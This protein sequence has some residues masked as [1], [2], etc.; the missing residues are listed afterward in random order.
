MRIQSLILITFTLLLTGCNSNQDASKAEL[1]PVPVL[2]VTPTV[3]DVPVYIESIGTLHPSI[4]MEIRPQVNGTLRKV[5][6][7]EGEWVQKGTPLFKIDPKPYLNKVQETEAQLAMDRA[8]QESAQKKLERFKSLAEKDLIPQIEWDEIETQVARSQ[9]AVEADEARLNS[10]KLDL[11]HCTLFSPLEGRIGKLDAHPGQLVTSGQSTP[12]VTLSKMDPLLVEFTITEKE[13]LKLPQN[14][15]EVEIQSLSSDAV[16]AKGV[17][18]FLDNH[19]DQKSGLLLVR[20]KVDN[21]N[22]ALRPG[23]SVRVRLVVETASNVKLIP[24]KAV[25]Y[26]PQGP[27]VYIVESDQSVGM[28]PVQLGDAQANDVIVLE[29]IESIDRVITD[30]HLRLYP[31]LKVEVSQ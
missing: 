9:A 28:R 31:G 20:G 2:A 23:Q 29:G 12:L 17:I 6:I 13:F 3:K 24:Q 21:P 19:F 4:F 26:N 5:L 14:R 1:P 7:S 18:T 10:A 25:K 16:Q 8:A 30:G 15:D 27:Y 22:L 11:E